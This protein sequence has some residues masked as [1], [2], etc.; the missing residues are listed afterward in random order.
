LATH[1]APPPELESPWVPESSAPPEGEDEV[2]NDDAVED[3]DDIDDGS[4][5]TIPTSVPPPSPLPLPSP[6]GELQA[7]ARR[8]IAYNERICGN[9]MI[10]VLLSRPNGLACGLY[11]SDTA[12]VSGSGR[13]RT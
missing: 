3:D 4:P 10:V 12:P 6:P 9:T 13:L 1:G 2:G 8:R 7:H 5:V 11:A